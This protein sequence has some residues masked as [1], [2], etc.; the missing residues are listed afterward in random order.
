VEAPID[1]RI[2]PVSALDCER[3][4][5]SKGRFILDAMGYCVVLNFDGARL[6]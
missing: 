2:D 5:P 3:Y 6:F 4:P 1:R